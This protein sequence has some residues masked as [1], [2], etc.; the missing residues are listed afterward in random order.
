MGKV[1]LTEID[2]KIIEM[3]FNEPEEVT[4][5]QWPDPLSDEAYH[6]LAGD[7]VRKVQERTEADPSAILISFL[8]LFG[9]AIGRNAHFVAEADK[10]YCN[11]FS[12]MVGA[13]AKGRKGVSIGIAKMP[14]KYQ[15]DWT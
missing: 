12:C 14:F 15:E 2:E 9:N 3:A 13:T 10:H 6:G 1:E 7:F 11:L 4:G 5:L 8:T